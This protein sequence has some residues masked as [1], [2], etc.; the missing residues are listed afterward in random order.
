[1]TRNALFAGLVSDEDDRPIEVVMVGGEAFYV[2]DDDGFMRHVECEHVDR[3]V[4]SHFLELIQGHESLISEQTMK[5]IGQEDIFTKAAIET[6]L[7]NLD[8]QL[9]TI[10]KQGLPDEV[11]AYLGMLG[12]RVIIDVH[13]EV[14]RIDQPE[15]SEN[16]FDD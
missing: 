1:V 9:D 12:F 15:A 14:I 13:G 7:Q 11:R 16:P 2:V 5:M 3:Q 8:D 4:L 10:L 6:S